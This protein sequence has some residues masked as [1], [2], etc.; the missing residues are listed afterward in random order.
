MVLPDDTRMVTHVNIFNTILKSHPFEHMN[1]VIFGFKL[2]KLAPIS[3]FPITVKY[4][5]SVT[6]R[7]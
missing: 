3:D 6:G 5:E 4:S 7:I 2:T 1:R